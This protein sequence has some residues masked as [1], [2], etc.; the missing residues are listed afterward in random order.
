VKR[1][2]VAGIHQLEE[3][4]RRN[5]ETIRQSTVH[6]EGF[7][8]RTT[9]IDHS[10]LNGK[11]EPRREK[12]SPL[13]RASCSGRTTTHPARPVMCGNGGQSSQKVSAIQRSRKRGELTGENPFLDCFL[14]TEADISG[15]GD[16]RYVYRRRVVEASCGHGVSGFLMMRKGFGEGR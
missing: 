6:A 13:L 5:E 16:L 10:P 12:S 8:T 1:P 2:V 11:P 3:K 7:T 15:S 4:Q 9:V 14:K